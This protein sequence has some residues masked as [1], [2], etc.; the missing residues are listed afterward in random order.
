MKSTTVLAALAGV[1]AAAPLEPRIVA[2][3]FDVVDF[4]AG[5]QPHGSLCS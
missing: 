5:C 1:A 3:E 4:T 2:Q